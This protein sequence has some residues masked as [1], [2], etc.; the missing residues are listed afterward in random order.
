[1]NK[2]KCSCDQPL[3]TSI[4]GIPLYYTFSKIQTKSIDS[5]I[6]LPKYYPSIGEKNMKYNECCVKYNMIF[7][8]LF[9][10][11]L[12]ILI[13]LYNVGKI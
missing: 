8:A 9:L 1:M 13:I 11:I 7:V 4:E 5:T 10:S 12:I 6:E 3:I 2:N